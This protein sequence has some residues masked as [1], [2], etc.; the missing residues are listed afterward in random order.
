MKKTSLF[1]LVS[2]GICL[3]LFAGIL[4]NPA[5]QAEGA[6]TLQISVDQVAASGLDHPVFVTNAG[7]SSKRLFVIEQPGQIKI[8]QNGQVLSVPFIDI[9][10]KVSYGGERGL[11]GLAFHPGYKTNGY[12]Y[13]DYTRLSDGATVIERYQVSSNPNV[14]SMAS[15]YTLLVIPQP[16][17]NHN[18]GNLAFGPDGKLYIGMG[19]GGSGG[20]PQNNAQN[21]NSL[22]GKILRI[23][24]DSA[25]PY[26]IPADNPFVG[27]AGADE[28]WAYG[29][30]NPWRYSFDR[31]TGDMLIGDVGQNLWEEIDYQPAGVGGLNYG[32]RCYEGMHTYNL[33]PPCSGVLT[34]PIA[35][36]DHSEGQ[37]ITGGYVYRGKRFPSMLGTYFYADFAQGKIWAMKK[38]STTWS[39]PTLL[40]DT[41]YAISSF[42]EDEE[43]EIYIA[44]YYGGTLR[45][46]ADAQGPAPNLS[47]SKKTASAQSADVGATLV[48]TLTLKNT[49]GL[50]ISN[51]S[52][53]DSLPSGLTYVN[54]TLQANAGVVNDSAAPTL[55]WDGAVDLVSPVLI[56][57]QATVASPASGN[58]LNQAQVTAP[59]LSPLTLNAV[60]LV[61]GPL[62]N[63]TPADIFFPGTQPNNL[64]DPILL[65]VGCDVCHSAPI[66][67]TWQGSMMAQA[68][69][70]PLMWAALEIANR[71]APDSGE[72]CLRCHTPKGW[73]EGRSQAADGSLLQ[74]ADL[75]AGVSCDL[76]HR[77]VEPDPVDG[78]LDEASTYDASVRNAIN[79]KPPLDHTGSAMLIMDLSDNRRGPFSL[80]ISFGPHPN[81][82]FQTDFLGRNQNDFVERSRLCGTC[83]NVDNPNLTWDPA[84]QQYW[85]NAMGQPAPSFD[86]GQ[87]FTIETTYDE[88]LN[89]QYASTGVIAPR[90]A[91]AKPGGLVGA[92]QDCH[93]P[94]ATG[95][96]ADD[97]LDPTYRDCVN[98]GCLP[99][100]EFV[101]GNTWVPQLLL[102]SRWRLNGLAYQN[103]I[104]PVVDRATSMLRRSATL[105]ATLQTSPNAQIVTLRVTNQ[106][107]HKLPTGYAEGRRMWINLKAYD[108][109]GNLVFESGHYNPTTG[110]LT[111]DANLKVYEV[112]QGMT[113][114]L[115]AQVNLPEGESFHFI[116]NNTVVKDNRIPPHG[117]SQAA[118][119][120]PG[121]TPVGAVYQPG[122]YWDDTI[123]DLSAYPDVARIFAT[124][125]YQTS[126]KEYIDFLRDNGGVDAVT[127]GSLWDTL[128]SPPEIVAQAW[129]PN[130]SH[131]LPRIG[132]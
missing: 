31:Q 119:D 112:K 77:M 15:A 35:E 79:P 53:V 12:F 25:A 94:R 64:V 6:G 41:P 122:Q 78:N 14:A 114:E 76:C 74:P 73:L 3:L 132:K 92:C 59:G 60:V 20:D 111:Q 104:S 102:D 113:P 61:P 63:T 8:L 67:D 34:F 89:S 101:G 75:D 4:L 23:D 99:V 7:D 43:G 107:G 40:L 85:P 130:Y 30:R 116:L 126:S 84:R 124:L 131:Y 103:F 115:A 22:L 19:D 32:W 110:I 18:G 93:M 55:R 109:A 57:Y 36:Y 127:L 98:T 117:F 29:V 81:K 100:H 121:L 38:D 70:D 9:R 52:V 83:H 108:A 66:Y 58:R 95:K 16:Y 106:T 54:G 49:G 1:L 46:L 5:G 120:T 21:I 69:R 48:Y 2:T 90:F 87:L 88:W 39:S 97:V 42:G 37:S 62:L 45:L 27:K 105:T 86:K 51:V 125:Y 72:Y 129:I 118:L 56:T 44:D 50:S 68:G 33:N 96:A 10:S 26:G 11:L 17:S 24:V 65:P 82:T 13:V 71:D 123:Y 128:K 91:G 47:T 80:G 28:I